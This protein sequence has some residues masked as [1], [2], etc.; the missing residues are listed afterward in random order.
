L[1]DIHSGEIFMHQTLRPTVLVVAT[2]DT[3]GVEALYLKECIEREGCN[4]I[5]M[6]TGIL[7]EPAV[8]SDISREYVARMGGATIEELK[9]SGDNGRYIQTMT[10]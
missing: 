5:L 6:D 9:A 7:S 10:N 4:T 2:L 3:K 1:E 8:K